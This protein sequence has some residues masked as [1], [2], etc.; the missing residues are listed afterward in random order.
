M[1]ED[2]AR[3]ARLAIHETPIEP[4]G[5][6]QTE[7]VPPPGDEEFYEKYNPESDR[8]QQVAQEERPE[9][10]RSAEEQYDIPSS[11]SNIFMRDRD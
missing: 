5:E 7:A 2:W 3:E 11:I 10:E 1:Q 6:P 4:L 8:E 9:E